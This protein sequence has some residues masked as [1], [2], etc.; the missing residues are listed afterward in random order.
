MRPDQD[1]NLVTPVATTP[2]R[3]VPRPGT[4]VPPEPKRGMG[5]MVLIVVAA[6]IVALVA[7]S[8]RDTPESVVPETPPPSAA[9]VP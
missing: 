5:V 3:P 6:A 2:A 7:W 8:V 4:S 1:P 9:P